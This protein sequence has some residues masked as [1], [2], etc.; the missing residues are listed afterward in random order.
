VFERPIPYRRFHQPR[1]VRRHTPHR[2]IN[3]GSRRYGY[4]RDYQ[5]VVHRRHIYVHWIFVPVPWY[6]RTG[7]V[8]MDDY[9]WWVYNGYR[10]R[11]NPVDYCSYEVVDST[12]NTAV[13]SYSE[14]A[15][16][17]GYDVCAQERDTYNDL[18]GYDRYFCA[19]RVEDEYANENNDDVFSPIPTEMDEAQVARIQQYLDSH[20]YL[21]SYNDAAAQRLGTC[22]VW[23]L[24]NNPYGCTYRAKVDGQ[25]Y[26][27]I[28]GE[29]CSIE[30][31]AELIG[32][33]VGTEKQNVGCILQNAV[34]NGY[35]G[36]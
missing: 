17:V 9:P 7:Y 28:E 27:D 15:C 5:R 6:Y 11:Y 21:D 33:N 24:R 32:C 20:G 26:P 36:I 10:Y 19:E 31:Q 34:L 2:D 3:L 12:T 4:W 29:V 22:T 1:V 18:E 30:D 8:V 35:C 23:R 25:N 14:M 13:R 16:N